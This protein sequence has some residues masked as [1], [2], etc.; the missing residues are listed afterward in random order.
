MDAVARQSRASKAT[1][2]RCRPSKT[3][4]VVAAEGRSRNWQVLD[5]GELLASPSKARWQ[6]HCDD[7]NPHRDEGW[8]NCYWFG[9]VVAS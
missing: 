8:V 1:I 7:C 5:L 3:A 2:Y 4:L 6:V 9:V